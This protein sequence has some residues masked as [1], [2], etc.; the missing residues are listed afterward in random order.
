MGRN[1]KEALVFTSMMC[2]M[3]VVGMSFYNVLLFNGANSEVFIQVAIGLLPALVVALFLDIVVVSRIA[4][5]LAFKIVKP[6][7]PMIKKV[8]TISIFMVCG[9]VICMS[10]YGTLAHYGFGDNFLRHYL[11]ILGL[12]FICALPLQL[13]VVGPLTRL[14]FTRMF[15][16][17][18]SVQSA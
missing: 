12:N 10:L 7:D 17:T 14:L 13:L 11:S 18:P 8:M 1:K 3:M 4:K 16:V 9:M 5:G 2:F 15:P 6:S